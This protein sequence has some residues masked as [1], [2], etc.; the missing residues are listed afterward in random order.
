MSEKTKSPTRVVTSKV[1]F[2][3]AHVFEP[4]SMD[5]K[6]DKKYSVTILVPKKDKKMVERLKSAVS[7]AL[8]EGKTKLGGKIPSTFKNPIR[9]GDEERPDDEAFE[10]MIFLNANSPRK[11]GLVDENLDAIIDKDEFYSGCYGRASVNFYAFNTSGNKGVAVGLNNLQKLED[12]E[13]LSGDFSTPEEDFG[14]QD[15]LM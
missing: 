8:E 5:E 12:G 3:Y 15:E 2:C 7:A 14:D 11:P 9:D 13:R 6:S 1:R 4:T 10:G